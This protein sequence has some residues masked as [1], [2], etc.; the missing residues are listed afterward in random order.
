MAVNVSLFAGITTCSSR[1][2]SPVWRP[3]NVVHSDQS[4]CRRQ[5]V[6]TYRLVRYAAD[7]VVM[8]GGTRD[9][10]EALFDEVTTVLAQEFE[11][12]R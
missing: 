2:Q 1:R 7:F 10:A 5:G 11:T 12:I 4:K 3:F 6:P 8:V 9:D